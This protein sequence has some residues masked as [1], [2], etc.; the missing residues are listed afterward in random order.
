MQ[1]DTPRNNARQARHLSFISDYTTDM[2]HIHGTEN[3][4]ADTLS[5]VQVHAVFHHAQH[6]DWAQFAEAQKHDASIQELIKNDTSLKMSKL[7]L[8]NQ[9]AAPA[10]HNC[11]GNC[12]NT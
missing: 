8:L 9:S 10:L 4:V 12:F 6:M 2:Q 11:K 5:R 1:S 3:I 7:T